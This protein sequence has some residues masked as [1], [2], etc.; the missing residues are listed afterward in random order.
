MSFAAIRSSLAPGAS[1][2]TALVLVLTSMGAAGLLTDVSLSRI[3][4]YAPG[5][6][7]AQDV[8]APIPYRYLDDGATRWAQEEAVRAVPPIFRYETDQVQ[9]REIQLSAAFVTARG[10]LQEAAD[11]RGRVPLETQQ[12]ILHDLEETLQIQ[13]DVQDRAILLADGFS[14][15]TE[16]LT[17]EL[18]AV[19]GRYPIVESRDPLPQDGPILLLSG[20]GGM[21]EERR[22]EDLSRL[23]TVE[24]TGQ[25]IG[26]Y[27]ME[28]L[29]AV[30]EV[31]R[32]KVAAALAR[33]ALQADCRYD[34]EEHQRRQEAARL[35]VAPVE[36]DV[37]RGKRIVRVGDP[38]TPS[39]AAELS[40]LQANTSGSD[41][42]W[43]F[44][45]HLA[46]SGILITSLS[47]FARSTIRK[48]APRPQDLEAMALALLLTIPAAGTL[49]LG[50]LQ[51]TVE[52]LAVKKKK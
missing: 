46:F 45:T 43:M 12:A 38:V 20:A 49:D 9:R 7:P 19:G 31:Q 22:L 37:P 2:R 52:Q 29:S 27:V 14:R 42:G 48:F 1:L 16:A 5:E 8:V 13:L 15:E 44:L 51:L 33:R 47:H 23:R 10:R 40:A 3:P 26:L 41:G 32:V 21:T 25:A 34:A 17:T 4:S 50:E 39:Q 36:V 24:E 18:I 30:P 28:R 11:A 6:V 35:S